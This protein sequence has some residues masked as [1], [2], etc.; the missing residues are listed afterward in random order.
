[1]NIGYILLFL[2][3]LINQ[4]FQIKKKKQKSATILIPSY[5]ELRW[6]RVK[7]EESIIAALGDTREQ[8]LSELD[9]NLKMQLF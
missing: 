2:F 3:Y 8:P 7:V 6:R 4:R 9:F 5:D 1:M